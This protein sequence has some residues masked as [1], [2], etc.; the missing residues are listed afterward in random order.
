MSGMALALLMQAGFQVG[1]RVEAM[2]IGTR[3][4]SCVIL[5]ESKTDGGYGLRCDSG[6]DFFVAYRNVRAPTGNAAPARPGN[7]AAGAPANA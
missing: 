4:E 7:E 1:D 6:S 2:P 5:R 3:W